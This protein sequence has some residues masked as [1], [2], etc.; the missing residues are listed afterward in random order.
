MVLDLQEDT[1][2]AQDLLAALVQSCSY[3]TYRYPKFLLHCKLK[4]EYSIILLWGGGSEYPDSCRLVLVPGHTN[5]SVSKI[6]VHRDLDSLE[7]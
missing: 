1:L 4:H 6:A 7:E 5:S 3:S 2:E